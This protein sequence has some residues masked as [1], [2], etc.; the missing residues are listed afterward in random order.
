MTKNEVHSII[1]LLALIL[2]FSSFLASGYG[3][4]VGPELPK[5]QVGNWWKFNIE[6][7]G[8]VNLVGTYTYMVVNDDAN[9]LQNEHNFNCYQ[10]DI[11]GEG[12]LSGEI[13]SNEL[14]G[15]WTITEQQY[16]TKSDQSWVAVYSTYQETFTVNDDSGATQISLIQKEKFTSTTTIET[17]YNPPF[18]ANKGF[19]LTVGKNWFA[20][21][22]ETTKTQTSADWNLE[23]TTETETYKKTFSV[24]RKESMT[25][26]IGQT[27]TYVIKR[28]DPDGA[29]AESYYSPEVGFDVKQI[30]CDSTGIIQVT[31]ELLDY[32]YATNDDKSHWFTIETLQIL[33]IL[34]IVV[35]ATIAVILFL[36]RRRI[37]H[38]YQTN[39]VSFQRLQSIAR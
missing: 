33:I 1:L 24:L 6:I 11:S 37:D 18:E 39:D 16:Y 20:E 35:I 38:Q 34:A 17:T 29:Y 15:T 27:E 31:L 19:P 23:S 32:S 12:I 13:D 2:L 22:T 21:T 30:D 8:E 26:P 10:I 9:V 36:K 14:E 28:I 4:T 3:A 5:W 7:L 25:L